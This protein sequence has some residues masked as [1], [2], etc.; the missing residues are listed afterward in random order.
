MQLI[1]VS[2]KEFNNW[3]AITPKMYPALKTF[4]G[5]E[6]TRQILAMQICNTAGQMGYTPQ[7]QNMYTILGDNE[8][9]DTTA[10]DTTITNVA[11]LTT[12]STI[13]A[14]NTVQK[15]IINA[16]NQLN[17]NQAALIQQMAAMSLHSNHT[18]PPDQINAPPIQQ[19]TISAQ[20]P[21]QAYLNTG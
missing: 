6:Y 9:E 3:E 12:V 19:L 18:L 7:H 1:I 21:Y 16:I 10:T 2:F 11:A 17:E 5:G 15:S 13:T 8:D 4:I 20:V 14:S